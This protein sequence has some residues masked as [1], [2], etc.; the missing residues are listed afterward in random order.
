MERGQCPFPLS[1][2]WNDGEK[3]LER[4]KAHYCNEKGTDHTHPGFYFLD[5]LHFI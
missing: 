4:G 1:D 2:Q 5:T 3:V